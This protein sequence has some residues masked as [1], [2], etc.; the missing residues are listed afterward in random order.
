MTIYQAVHQSTKGVLKCF[1]VWQWFL[2]FVLVARWREADA[3]GYFTDLTGLTGGA[4]GVPTSVNSSGQVT[5]FIGSNYHGFLYSGGTFTDIGAKLGANA[6]TMGF[7]INDSGQIA[8]TPWFTADYTDGYLY[9]GGTNG[10]TQRILYSGS[11]TTGGQAA[12]IDSLGEVVGNG[13]SS[14]INGGNST[15]YVA[16][17]SGVAQPLAFPTNIPQ[18]PRGLLWLRFWCEPERRIRGRVA[19]MHRHDHQRASRTGHRRD[20]LELHMEQRVAD[21]DPHRPP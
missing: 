10:T 6:A 18:Q 1:I 19:P 11:T 17:S 21:L 12:A 8:A 20:S 2:V 7:G 9:S 4:S 16:N 5:G 13:K 14:S 3:A 15:A